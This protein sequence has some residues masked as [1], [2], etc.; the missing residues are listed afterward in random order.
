MINIYTSNNP[1]TF[2]EANAVLRGQPSKG[3]SEKDKKMFR[4]FAKILEKSIDILCKTFPQKCRD[5][6]PVYRGQSYCVSI[7]GQTYT[8]DSFLST[9]KQISQAELFFAECSSSSVLFE[10]IDVQGIYVSD[11]SIYPR[12][13]EVLIKP[14]AKFRIT[15]NLNS[16]HVSTH[17]PEIERMIHALKR[18][19]IPKA[20][21]KGTM[22]GFTSTSTA[23]SGQDFVGMALAMIVMYTSFGI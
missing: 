7:T 13:E 21:I 3:V 12:E 20:F 6:S 8:F 11:Y 16:S 22:I 23:L 18:T 2:K 9:S 4:E 19:K 17:H 1:A 5:N 14:T 15:L 10:M